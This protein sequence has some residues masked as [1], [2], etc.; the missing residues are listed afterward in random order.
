MTPVKQLLYGALLEVHALFRWYKK[1]LQRDITTP[2][3]PYLQGLPRYGTIKMHV[4]WNVT[5]LNPQM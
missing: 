1:E 4:D 3:P 5:L 2:L